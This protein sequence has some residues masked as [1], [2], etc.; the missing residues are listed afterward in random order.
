M[1]RKRHD[2]RMFAR[3]REKHVGLENSSR[4]SSGTGVVQ[5]GAVLLE[6]QV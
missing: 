1:V 6:A 3:V 4:C 2:T 5:A